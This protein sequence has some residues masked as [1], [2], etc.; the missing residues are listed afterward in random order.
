MVF[1]ITPQPTAQERAALEAALALEIRAEEGASAWADGLLPQR[2][3]ELE[4]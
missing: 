4:A 2:D 1:E 3:D